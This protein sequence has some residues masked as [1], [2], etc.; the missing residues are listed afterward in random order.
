MPR[1]PLPLPSVRLEI[2]AEK[3]LMIVPAEAEVVVVIVVITTSIIVRIIHPQEPPIRQLKNTPTQFY[4]RGY[5]IIV[6]STVIYITIRIK[7]YNINH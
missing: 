3:D 4:K 5:K 2:E 7:N 6:V 1:F